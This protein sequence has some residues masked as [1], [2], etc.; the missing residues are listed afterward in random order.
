MKN[1]LM[2]V[3]VS[4]LI[5]LSSPT[6]KSQPSLL[7]S[8]GYLE[9]TNS[10]RSLEFSVINKGT[11]T[12][13]YE[14]FPAFY[15]QSAYLKSKLD[16]TPSEYSISNDIKI[17]PKKFKLSPNES[18]KI[19]IIALRSFDLEKQKH[20]HIKI[21]GYTDNRMP[22][23]TQTQ[24]VAINQNIAIPIFTYSKIKAVCESLGFSENFQEINFSKKGEVSFRGRV[25]LFRS[26]ELIYEKNI[27]IYPEIK[28]GV[29]SLD[30]E[31][32]KSLR[33]NPS[34]IRVSFEEFNPI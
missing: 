2:L 21:K 3:V 23:L 25:K 7:A 4:F 8:T 19:R 12:G 11:T 9:I 31:I 33:S 30:E 16:T 20:T 29:I 32:I 22:S 14:I 5:T 34:Y 26:N 6:V 10:Q 18:Q 28:K 17:F 27:T 15:T 13:Y 1:K 24:S